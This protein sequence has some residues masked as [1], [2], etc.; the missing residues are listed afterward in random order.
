MTNEAKPYMEKGKPLPQR[1]L[2]N[3]DNRWKRNETISIVNTCIKYK[4]LVNQT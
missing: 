4:R 2:E 1:M 3:L